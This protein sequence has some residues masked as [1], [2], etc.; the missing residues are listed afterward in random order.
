MIL[1]LYLLRGYSSRVGHIA[2]GLPTNVSK[3][4]VINTVT[5][6]RAAMRHVAKSALGQNAISVTFRSASALLSKADITR[7]MRHGR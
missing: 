1:S 5:F 6:G 4:A 3:E 7:P 2:R